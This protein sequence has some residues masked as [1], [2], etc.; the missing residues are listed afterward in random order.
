PEVDI[1]LSR[2][3]STALFRILQESLTNVTRHAE[4]KR[5]SITLSQDDDWMSLEVKDDGKGISVFD[6]ESS[7]SFGLMGMRERAHVFGGL[8][9]RMFHKGAASASTRARRLDNNPGDEPNSHR[10]GA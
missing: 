1:E 10:N 4:A 3:A 5:V 9:A 6:L 2:D 7:R 8:L